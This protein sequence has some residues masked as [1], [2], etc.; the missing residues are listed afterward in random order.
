MKRLSDVA[1]IYDEQAKANEVVAEE[2]LTRVESFP[3]EIRES[4]RW[5]A[6]WLMAEAAGWRASAERLRS[7]ECRRSLNRSRLC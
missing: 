4:L 5:R 6:G 7:V 2:I 3:A 1:A